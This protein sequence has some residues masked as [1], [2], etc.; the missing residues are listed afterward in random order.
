MKEGFLGKQDPDWNEMGSDDSDE[1]NEE[2]YNT[3]LPQNDQRRLL[4]LTKQIKERFDFLDTE[5]IHTAILECDFDSEKL[6]KYLEKYEIEDKYK[7]INAFEWK[8]IEDKPVVNKKKGRAN[9]RQNQREH[10]DQ[11]QQN[12]YRPNYYE[13]QNY[14]SYQEHYEEPT[15]DQTEGANEEQEE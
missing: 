15:H 12:Y 10:N 11:Y 14:H 7:G 6:E 3:V 5:E 2:N 13:Q 9:K 4:T 8:V 1:E